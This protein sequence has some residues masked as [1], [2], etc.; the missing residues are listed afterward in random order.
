MRRERWATAVII[1][2]FGVGTTPAWAQDAPKP[3]IAIADVAVS[4]G[5]WTLPPPQMGGTIVELLVGELVGSQQFHVYDG[6][7]LVPQQ[8]AGGH[9]NLARLREAAAGR[10]V[11]YLVLGSV[12]AFSMVQAKNHGGALVP[13]RTIAGGGM[14]TSSRST[15]A[16]DVSFR[17][18]DVRTGEIITTAMAEGT[19]T[20]KASGLGLLGL[21]RGIPLP[22]LMGMA[23]NVANARDAM[24]N[25]ALQHAVHNAALALASKQL[26]T[27]YQSSSAR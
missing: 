14:Y 22:F 13:L 15:V 8:E 4:P 2:I 12:T 10:H 17:I 7:W 3:T 27:G 20:R 25:E 5:G 18:V 26:P 24:L 16:V 19:G 23:H 21:A 11:D 1:T 9:V 6:Q